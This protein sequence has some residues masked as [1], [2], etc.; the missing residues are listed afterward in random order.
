MI[1]I[2]QLKY[3]PT[4]TKI[5]CSLPHQSVTPNTILNNTVSSQVSPAVSA[6]VDV[7]VAFLSLF[8]VI[9]YHQFALMFTCTGHGQAPEIMELCNY[10]ESGICAVLEENDE[11][12]GIQINSSNPALHPHHQLLWRWDGNIYPK[13]FFNL[14]FSVG[15][16][17]FLWRFA[18]FGVWSVVRCLLLIC[19]SPVLVRER[20]ENKILWTKLNTVHVARKYSSFRWL[21]NVM[22]FTLNFRARLFWFVHPIILLHRI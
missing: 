22:N 20:E 5:F 1:L 12:N 13:L 7:I 11:N 8:A 16:T 14:C 3:S 17:V 19:G 10:L 2:D 21:W 15:Q 18:P 4:S 9:F 6:P